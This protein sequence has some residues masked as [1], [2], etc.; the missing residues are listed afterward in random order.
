MSFQH[1]WVLVLLPLAL[2]SLW[3]LRRWV[4]RGAALRYSGIALVSGLPLSPRQRARSVPA[5]LRYS[6]LVLALIALA[7]PVVA[8]HHEVVEGEGIDI[9]IVLDISGSMRALDF[10]PDDRLEVAK[11][12]IHEFVDGRRHDRIALVVFAA[13][14][15]TQCPLT[16]DYGVLHRFLDE[17]RVGL[18]EDG[19][20]IG[21]GI[22]T[23]VKRLANSEAKSKML[24]LLTDG[25]NNVPTVDPAT[26]AEAARALGVR[27]YA[28]GVGK[29]GT[30][31]YP[32]DHPVLGRRYTQIETQIDEDLL[33]R[34]AEQT[35]GQYFRA[36]SGEGL[37]R[38][39]E[40]IDELETSRIETT[41]Y[42]NYHQ[43]SGYFLFPALILLLLES[44]LAVTLY[45]VLP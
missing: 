21:L 22:A 1:P 37:A 7:R 9:S 23:G 36:R 26:A 44:L 8:D 13:K 11:S 39:F 15:F 42:T 31:P 10:Q 17:V 16:L 40:L 33:K 28:I 43:L 3:A 35:G 25:V 41:I 29:E 18:I 6:A 24:I 14:A 27:I 30:A 19:T 38:I 5:F 20:A 45:R 12:V 32:V 34:V 4:G 2:I